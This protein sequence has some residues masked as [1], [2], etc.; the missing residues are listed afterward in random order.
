MKTT[1]TEYLKQPKKDNL[2]N[3]AIDDYLS[4]IHYFTAENAKIIIFEAHM[5]PEMFNHVSV[6]PFIDGLSQMFIFPFKI[7]HR[8]FDSAEGLSAYTKY[9]KGMWTDPDTLN[10]PIFLFSFHGSPGKPETILG[11]ISSENLLDCFDG[12]FDINPNILVFNSCSLFGGEKGQKLAIELIKKSG[13]RAVLGFSETLQWNTASITL[14]LFLSR[15]I[16]CNFPFEDLPD[17]FTSIIH[18]FLPSGRDLG[19]SLFLNPDFY[20]GK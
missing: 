10:T 19:F 12:G 20:P 15:F 9:P 16:D 13:T 17:I 6:K 2:I 8:I 1:L 14:L 4:D 11:K 3:T 7:S 5:G 18:D